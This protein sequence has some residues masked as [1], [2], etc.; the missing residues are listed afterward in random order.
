MPCASTYRH[1]Q[2]VKNGENLW[3]IARKYNVTISSIVSLNKLPNRNF[4]RPGMKLKIPTDGNIIQ[5]YVTSS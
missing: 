4:I 3:L 5:Y 1:E 2:K